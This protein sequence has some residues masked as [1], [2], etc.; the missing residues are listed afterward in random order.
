MSARAIATL[1][2]RPELA[3]PCAALARAVWPR[4][5]LEADATDP[6]PGDRAALIAAW[7]AWQCALL[8]DARVVAAAQAVPVR[9]DRDDAHLP[10]GWDALVARGVRLHAGS[11]RPRREGG[12]PDALGLVAIVVD[13]AHRGA[14]CAAALIAHLRARASALGWPVI[15][16]LRATW[17]ERHPDT[18]LAA[19]ARW[20]T[21]EGEPYDPWI[22]LHVRAGARIV[23]PTAR[24]VALT[25]T[26]AQWRTWTGCALEREGAHAIPGGLAPLRVQAG[27][28][29]YAEPRL[30]VVYDG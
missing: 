30:W 6:E 5:L 18:D 16:P 7:P 21:P 4:F 2:E 28:G 12:T 3:A 26:V 17:K 20:T 1:A 19:Y 25:G 22:R 14:G 29:D 15:A 10:S 11:L 8:D 23:G 24:P 27:R 13:P 9:W